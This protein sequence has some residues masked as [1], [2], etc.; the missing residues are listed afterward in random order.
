LRRR[1]R[2]LVI[3]A[4]SLGITGGCRSTIGAFGESAQSA[5]HNA[6]ELFAAFQVRFQNVKRDS[7]FDAARRKMAR[8]ALIPAALYRDTA[9]WTIVSDKDSSRAMYARAGAEGDGYRFASGDTAP[10]PTDLGGE[11]HSLRLRSLGG[12]EFEWTTSVD[13]AVGRIKPALVGSALV[14]A[15]TA[16]ESRDAQNALADAAGAF[17]R[18]GTHLSQLLAIDS[19]RTTI[20]GDGSTAIA[21]GLTVRTDRLRTGY[22]ALAAYLDKYL[23]P[24]IYEVLLTDRRGTAYFRLWGREG[25]V[26]VRL[27]ASGGRL[28]ALDGLARPLPD[29]LLLHTDFSAR[30]RLF[31]IGFSELV[32]DFTVERDEHVRA[33]MLRSRREPAWHFPFA[34]D[35]L[36]RSPLRRPFQGEGVEL[37]LGVR[38]DL[39]PQTMSFRYV[40]LAVSESAIMRWLGRLGAT[41]FG[42]FSGRVEV[43]E[44]RFLALL[45]AALRQDN[46]AAP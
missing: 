23:V 37:R 45:F 44:D 4:A 20:S 26:F 34:M 11:R 15:L 25:H 32:T 8:L 41:A 13:H 36:I 43:D 28:V 33:W 3:V 17:P 10:Y 5:R 12:S 40:R 7:K 38:D 9:V 29:S 18:A 30:Y 39:G 22:P 2:I 46:S 35:K 27:R 24:S 16:A 42:E 14:A 21:L 6:D 1:Y 19:L 31:R